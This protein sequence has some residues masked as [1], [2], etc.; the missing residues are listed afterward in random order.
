MDLAVAL[1]NHLLAQQP[2]VRVGLAA[3]AGRRVA[4]SIAPFAVAGVLTEDGWLAA[5]P[6]EP[7]ATLAVAPLAALAAQLSGRAPGFDSLTLSGDRELAQG[8]AHLAAQLRWLPVEDVARLCGDVAANRIEGAVR[9]IAGV[10]G[11]IVWRLADN[12]LEHLREE[13]PLLARSRDVQQFTTAVD[14]LRDDVERLEKRLR[15]LEADCGQ[16]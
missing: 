1:F 10:K 4:L 3:L 16:H 7:E 2:E 13:S 11:A 9:R 14:T 8:F 6:G 5:S 12:W 15:R